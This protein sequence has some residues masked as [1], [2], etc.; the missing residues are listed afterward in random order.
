MSQA[1]EKAAAAI[2]PLLSSVAV[3]ALGEELLY[4]LCETNA[5]D[6]RDRPGTV[7]LLLTPMG[8]VVGIPD[9]NVLW[10][11]E[12]YLSKYRGQTY[13]VAPSTINRTFARDGIE[14]N[15]LE[16]ASRRWQKPRKTT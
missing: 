14:Q 6:K 9:W 5:P 13:W 7:S 16:R 8:R 2:L 3:D 4:M 1:T 15:F 10:Q 12:R 11:V